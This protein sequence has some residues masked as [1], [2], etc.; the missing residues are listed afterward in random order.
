MTICFELQVHSLVNMSGSDGPCTVNV[1][2]ELS[3]SNAVARLPIWRNLGGEGWGWEVTSPAPYA[4]LGGEG[5]V[6]SPL[7]PSPLEVT[8]HDGLE[9]EEKKNHQPSVSSHATR[10]F[11]YRTAHA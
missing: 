8:D 7:F 1:L 6:K 10:Y 3:S 4:S 2:S 11:L 9:K 5:D